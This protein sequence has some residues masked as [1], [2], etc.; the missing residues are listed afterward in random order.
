VARE[1]SGVLSITWRLEAL[2]MLGVQDVKVLTLL[3][4]LFLPNVAP[5]SQQDF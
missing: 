2:Y 1:P 4:V 5:E 3:G